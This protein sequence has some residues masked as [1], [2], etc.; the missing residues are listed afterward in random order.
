MRAVRWSPIAVAVLLLAGC[1][2]GQRQLQAH[3]SP[4]YLSAKD[5]G[6]ALT[7]KRGDEFV[8]TLATNPSTGY[9]W[10]G[11]PSSH[12]LN[13]L[14]VI[15]H[16][17]IAAKTGVPGAPGKEIWRFRAVSHGGMDLGFLY[18]RTV[19]RHGTVPRHNLT[20]QDV[21]FSIDVG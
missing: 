18:M 12:P 15:S 1:G 5:S 14:R 9:R 7:L 4:L 13:P 16:R 10:E 6:A 3:G 11:A 20:A 2:A 21:D 19:Q 8:V 17:Y